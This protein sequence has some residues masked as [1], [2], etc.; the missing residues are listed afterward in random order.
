VAGFRRGTRSRLGAPRAA[1]LLAVGLFLWPLLPERLPGADCPE[2]GALDA[3]AAPSRRVGCDGGG[4]LRGPARLLFG[5]R[6]DPNRAQ[7]ASLES[8]PGIGPVRAAAI[9]AERER[10]PF[11]SLEALTRVHG[12]G[13][14]TL[15]GLRPWLEIAGAREPETRPGGD[16]RARMTP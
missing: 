12:I 4:P 10:R 8:L 2:A 15:E 5:L 16:A 11:G 7:A 13:P 3:P 9:V 1:W 14:R 6:L